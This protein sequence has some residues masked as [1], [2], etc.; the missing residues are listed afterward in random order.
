MGLDSYISRMEMHYGLPSGNGLFTGDML[1]YCRSQRMF[2][3]WLSAQLLGV[4]NN[5]FHYLSEEEISV[6]REEIATEMHDRLFPGDN[7]LPKEYSPLSGLCD[8]QLD[9]LSRAIEDPG[10]LYYHYSA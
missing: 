5:G 7:G 6:I 10:E 8:N 1:F 2:H 9:E 3:D 4:Q